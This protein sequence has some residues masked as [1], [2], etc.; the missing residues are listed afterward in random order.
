MDNDPN[1]ATMIWDAPVASG[2]VNRTASWRGTGTQSSPQFSPKIFTLTAGN[3]QLILRGKD[4]NVQ[5]SSLTVSPAYPVVKLQILS[6]AFLVSG[7]GPIGNNYD[8]LASQN[9]S[10]WTPIQTITMDLRGTFS[11]VDGAAAG[12]GKRYYRLR[13][14]P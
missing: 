4:P 12:L 11:M 10:T 6:G 7:V 2:F 9:L 3:H 14:A 5:L 13:A 1:S 8:L